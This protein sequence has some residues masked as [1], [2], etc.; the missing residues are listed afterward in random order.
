MNSRPISSSAPPAAAQLLA[1]VSSLRSAEGRRLSG[2]P[3]KLGLQ[4]DK[5]YGARVFVLPSTSGQNAGTSLAEKRK[6][7]KQLGT[8]LK[9]LSDA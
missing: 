4:K 5:L 7:F 6:Y 1:L 2:R 3:C 8:L 9:K